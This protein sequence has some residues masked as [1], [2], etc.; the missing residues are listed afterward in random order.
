MSGRAYQVQF[1]NV[2][3]ATVAALPPDVRSRFDTGIKKLAADPYGAGS[4]PIKE[5]DYRQALVG[6]CITSYYV[7]TTVEVVSVTRVQGPP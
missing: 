6:G 5:P 7:S 2:A 3:R 1:S 4:K